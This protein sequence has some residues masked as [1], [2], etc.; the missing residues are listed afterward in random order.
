VNGDD[1]AH[2][3]AVWTSGELGTARRRV[4]VR[5]DAE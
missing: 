3:Y 5:T 1:R 2:G 4:S